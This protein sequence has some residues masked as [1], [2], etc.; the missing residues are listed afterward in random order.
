MLF[1]KDGEND[2]DINFIL[3]NNPI[4]K[5]YKLEHLTFLVNETSE[6]KISSIWYIRFYQKFISSQHDAKKICTFIPSCSRFGTAAINHFG[7]FKGI[8][9]TSD[10]LQRCNNFSNSNYIIDEKT[11]RRLDTINKY[12]SYAN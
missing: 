7:F 1:S 12:S 5:N 4:I 10:R 3:N 2:Q 8:L 11:D 9:L 6:I